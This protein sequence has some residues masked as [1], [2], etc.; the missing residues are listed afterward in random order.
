MKKDKNETE[1]DLLMEIRDTLHR[2]E[3][4]MESHIPEPPEEHW[5]YNCDDC[6]KCNENGGRCTGGSDP[7]DN[8]GCFE[9]KRW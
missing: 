1:R 4:M 8:E 9:P 7:I 3:S 6:K 5:T 2:I